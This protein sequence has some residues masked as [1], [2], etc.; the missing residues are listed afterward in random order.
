MEEPSRLCIEL[1]FYWAASFGVE[2]AAYMYMY[3]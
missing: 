2:V 3:K 1:V